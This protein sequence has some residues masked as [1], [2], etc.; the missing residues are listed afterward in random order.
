MAA[1][2]HQLTGIKAQ[3]DQDGYYHARNVYPDQALL[4]LEAD[5]DRIVEQLEESGE[6][7][8]ARW[9]GAQTKELDGGKSSIIHTHNVQRYS[10]RWLEALQDERFLDIVEQIIGPDIVLHHTKLFQKPPRE[11]APFPMHQDWSYFPTQKDTMIAGIIFLTD[12]DVE[13]GGLRVYSGSH[14]LGRVA[15]SSGRV[16]SK[17]LEQYPLDNAQAVNARRGD[18][19]FFSYLTLHGS[20]PNRSDRYRKTVLAQVHSGSDYVVSGDRL[21]HVN[22]SLVLRGWNHHMTRERAAV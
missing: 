15:D 21:N 7:I 22:E 9:D 5:F 17:V 1:A 20:T 14:K 4:E 10:P 8:N 11:G 19:F 12:A 13:S 6:G 18:V 2:E 3:F 16:P